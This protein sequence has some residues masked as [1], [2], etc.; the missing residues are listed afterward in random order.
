M[1][2]N[3]VSFVFHF[4][5]KNAGM[6]AQIAPAATPAIAMMTM[7][8]QFGTESPMSIMQAATASEPASTW[9]SAPMFQNRILNAGVTASD[10]HSNIARFCSETQVLRFVPKAP[11]NIAAYI[12]IGSSPVKTIVTTAQTMRASIMAAALIAQ[13]LY[14]GSAALLEMCMKGT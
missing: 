11:L 8:S 10:M 3:R 12:C 1:R 13:A 5:L 7:S 9:P 6:N 4:A 2:V 14:Q